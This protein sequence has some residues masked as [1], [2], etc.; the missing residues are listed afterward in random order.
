MPDLLSDGW[1]DSDSSQDARDVEMT[2]VPNDLDENSVD[3]DEEMTAPPVDQTQTTD[4]RARVEEEVGP[5]PSQSLPAPNSAPPPRQY[6]ETGGSQPLPTLPPWYLGP[7]TTQHGEDIPT[8]LLPP[9]SERITAPQN[10]Q[11]DAQGP[12]FRAHT[13]FGMVMDGN[14][15]PISIS[16]D[17]FGQFLPIIPQPQAQTPQLGQPPDQPGEARDQPRQP[18]DAGQVP[19]FTDFV[20]DQIGILPSSSGNP[21]TGPRPPFDDPGNT[22]GPQFGRGLIVEFLNAVLQREPPEEKDNPERAAKLIKGLERVPVGLVKRMTRVDDIP[23]AHEDSTGAD[24]CNVPGCAICWDSLLLEEPSEDAKLQSDPTSSMESEHPTEE[25]D[26]D[27][28]PDDHT[29]NTIICLPCSHVFHKSCLI[30]WFS[31]PKHTTCPTCR[32]DIDPKNL[33]YTPPQ[34]P[35]PPPAQPVPNPTTAT[36]NVPPHPHPGLDHEQPAPP[37][38][39]SGGEH[40]DESDRRPSTDAHVDLPI[41]IP[42]FFAIQP[43]QGPDQLP[44]ETRNE[45]PN[46]RYGISPPFFGFDFGPQQAAFGPPPPPG[47]PAHDATATNAPRDQANGP[48]PMPFPNFVHDGVGHAHFQAPG[49]VANFTFHAP[50]EQ[51]M[52]PER[53]F[54]TV[55]DQAAQF[56]RFFAGGERGPGTGQPAGLDSNLGGANGEPEVPREW[57]PPPAPGPTLRQ[58]IEAK[59]RKAGLRCDDPSC[60]IG[61]SDEVPFPEAFYNQNSPSIKRVPILNDGGD[62]AVCG[63]FFHPACLVSAD[64]CAGWGAFK[65]G[66]HEY[67]VVGCPVCRSVGKVQREVWEE[68]AKEL[69]I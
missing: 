16:P 17:I 66:P 15:L 42:D 52:N 49:F 2:I 37:G 10:V 46:N 48:Q 63:H 58:R 26:S 47:H 50:S 45:T 57:M 55:R 9:Q 69:L 13:F 21:G 11:Q 43:Q 54:Q 53:T 36:V 61:P 4:R 67:E 44:R 51:D 40:N 60:G 31:K 1:S 29:S 64:R 22:G 35:R 56:F 20:A 33:T 65:E 62:E 14:G 19:P 32:F 12:R 68:G 24:G 30:P 39:L 18:G 28:A 25:A 27:P 59:E 34:R 3:E 23:G 8:N 7:A 6:T 41:P 38:P 5:L